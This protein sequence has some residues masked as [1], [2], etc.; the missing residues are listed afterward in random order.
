MKYRERINASS[1]G[2]EMPRGNQHSNRRQ[3][4]KNRSHSKIHQKPMGLLVDDLSLA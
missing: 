2:V 3:K 4:G 1:K